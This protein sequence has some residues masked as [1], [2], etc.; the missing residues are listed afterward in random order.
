MRVSG[1][2]VTGKKARVRIMRE[3]RLDITAQ[4]GIAATRLRQVGIAVVARG[5]GCLPRAPLPPARR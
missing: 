1:G 3:Q 5:G 2:M 4:I